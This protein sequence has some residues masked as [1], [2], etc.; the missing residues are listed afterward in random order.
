MTPSVETCTCQY[1]RFG[2]MAGTVILQ[3][4]VHAV[5]LEVSLSKLYG[6]PFVLQASAR[7][8]Q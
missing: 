2:A 8:L 3:P 4:D 1:T 6:E 7:P 5:P